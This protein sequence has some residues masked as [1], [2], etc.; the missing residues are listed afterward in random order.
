M[1]NSGQKKDGLAFPF[2]TNLA[3]DRDWK[4][5]HFIIIFIVL[6]QQK[7]NILWFYCP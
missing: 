3:M 5:D 1:S 6:K 7:C 2:Y 4:E